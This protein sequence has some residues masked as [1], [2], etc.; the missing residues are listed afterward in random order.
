MDLLKAAKIENT[1]GP[2]KSEDILHPQSK[3]CQ[4][5]LFLYSLHYNHRND[6][7]QGHMM[8]IDKKVL[9]YLTPL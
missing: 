9:E 5:I 4:F 2:I 3:T 7:W 6:D 1:D 8:T